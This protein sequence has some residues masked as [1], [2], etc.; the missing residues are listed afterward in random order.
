M[1]LLPTNPLLAV[2]RP[3]AR[4]KIPRHWSPEQARHFLALH[5][6]DGLYPVWAFLLGSGLRI[7]ELVFLRWPNVDL[8]QGLAR[9]T[10]SPRCWATTC[11]RHRARA[12]TPSAPS[13]STPT[14]PMCPDSSDGKQAEEQL[15]A[16]TYEQTDFVFT[17]PAGGAYQPQYL[18][19]LLGRISGELDLPRLTA[20]GLRHT[21]ATLML[22][23]GVRPGSRRS[24]S[25]PRCSRTSAATSPRPCR[26]RPPHRSERPSSG[27]GDA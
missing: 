26:R 15:A 11:S 12:T 2:P 27:T 9:S 7:G 17:K 25:A 20:H 23:S 19:K 8:D 10:S 4:K 3:K 1:G 5:E 24:A 21:S 6:G 22:A 16:P 14:W 18:S 13:T